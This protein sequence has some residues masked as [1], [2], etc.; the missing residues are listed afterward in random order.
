MAYWQWYLVIGLVL[1]FF[2]F[3]RAR[4]ASE[5]LGP[6]TPGFPFC[7]CTLMTPT[8]RAIPNTAVRSATRFAD[9]RWTVENI[10]SLLSKV[11]ESFCIKTT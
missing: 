2:D 3:S 11:F 6:I 10:S 5:I 8:T 1:A 9:D 4:V 7:A